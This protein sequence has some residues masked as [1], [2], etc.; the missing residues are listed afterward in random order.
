MPQIGAEDEYRGDE[1]RKR[2][3]ESISYLRREAAKIEYASSRLKGY[4]ED[5]FKKTVRY[6]RLGERD[7]AYI[8]ASEVAYLRRL[9]AA[10]TD[11]KDLITQLVL[12]LGS[13]AYTQSLPI[14]PLL[15]TLSRL[16]SG[17]P[18]EEL[19]YITKALC[20]ASTL[21]KPVVRSGAPDDQSRVVLEEA[22]SM[23][24]RGEGLEEPL[25]G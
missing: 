6:L 17:L 7:A 12:R 3:E 11:A 4:E 10:L 2:L 21:H 22:E 8:Y 5:C 16:P 19:G 25:A 1:A 20:E 15:E 14:V 9:Q 13:I 18:A 23:L 24:Q